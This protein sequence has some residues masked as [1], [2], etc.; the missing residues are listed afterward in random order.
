MT[1]RF[2]RLAGLILLAFLLGWA[3]RAWLDPAAVVNFLNQ[4][5]FCN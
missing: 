5:V 1:A 3:F 4:Q 2:L